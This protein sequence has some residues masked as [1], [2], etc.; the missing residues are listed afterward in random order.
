MI[1][2][3][4]TKNTKFFARQVWSPAFRRFFGKSAMPPEGGTPNGKTSRRL[5]PA[6]VPVKSNCNDTQKEPARNKS[7]IVTARSGLAR[8]VF[9]KR[10][11]P[12]VAA[13]ARSLR[14]LGL[15]NHAPA[16]A[17]QNGHSV[18]ETL[19]AG[20]PDHQGCSRCQPGQNPQAVGRTRLLHSRPKPAKGHAANC[21]KTQRQVSA[22]RS[23]ERRVG[24][25]CRS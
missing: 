7:E 8:L 4:N 15:R 10:P 12:A 11:G 6:A 20:T 9:A 24:K 5:H 22:V 19:D 2:T 25:E 21:G 1:T 17:G 3:K 16:N 14:H 18:L 23:E 13:H